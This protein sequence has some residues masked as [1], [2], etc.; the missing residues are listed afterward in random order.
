MLKKKKA[1]GPDEIPNEM[2][3]NGGKGLLNKLVCIVGKV[4]EGQGLP[5]YWKIGL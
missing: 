4:W 5:E 2:W 3:M 1:A